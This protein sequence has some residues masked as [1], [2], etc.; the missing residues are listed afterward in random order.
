[1]A[2]IPLG[3]PKAAPKVPKE[4]QSPVN[5]NAP[6]IA[7]P[8]ITAQTLEQQARA[9]GE[10]P[11]FIPVQP[12]EDDFVPPAFVRVGTSENAQAYANITSDA[13]PDGKRI[14][15]KAQYALKDKEVFDGRVA[16][17]TASNKERV[18]GLSAGPG[19][20]SM[21]SIQPK[22][23]IH[24]LTG[25]LTSFG[26]TD[27]EIVSG[28]A[29]AQLRA[30][31]YAKRYAQQGVGTLIDRDES[32]L[33]APDALFDAMKNSGMFRNKEEEDF[34]KAGYGNKYSAQY[35]TSP[36]Q[37]IQRAYKDKFK[38][39]MHPSQLKINID[40]Y[41][42]RLNPKNPQHKVL[43]REFLKWEDEHPDPDNM[44]SR[45]GKNFSATVGHLADAVGNA[46][47][48]S[49]S[50]VGY[51]E[52]KWS[53]DFKDDAAKQ[54][55]E[56]KLLILASAKNDGEVLEGFSAESAMSMVEK[57]FTKEGIVD[58]DLLDEDTKRQ[59]PG[60][61]LDIA[62][63]V[64]EL[65][66][67]GAFDK[68]ING[69]T[70]IL[71]FMS[72]AVTGGIGL[73]MIGV[74]SDPRSTTMRIN[75]SV[76][77]ISRY[78]LDDDTDKVS[79]SLSEFYEEQQMEGMNT[80][81]GYA[82]WHHHLAKE[83]IFGAGVIDSRW[84]EGGSAFL[85]PFEGYA[86]FAGV[87]RTGK[88]LLGVGRANAGKNF[89]QRVGLQE[90]LDATLASV[91]VLARQ[92]VRLD[93]FPPDVR[94]MLE[95][96][97]R[98]AVSANEK[99]DIYE[100][101]RRAYEGKGKMLDP[102]NPSR[103]VSASEELLNSLSNSI[104][105]KAKTVQTMRDKILEAANAGKKVVYSKTAMD[106]IAKA[107]DEL[108]NIFPE[109]DWSKVPDSVVYDRLRRGTMP[110]GANGKP[111]LTANEL[112]ALTR[113]VGRGW[114][115]I[116][117]KDI[118][119]YR[120]GAQ[121]P[122][123]FNFVYDNPIFNNAVKL[124]KGIGTGSQW[125]DDL[126]KTYGS[127]RS[128]ITAAYKVSG[129]QGVSASTL[130]SSN[131]G[132]F[133]WAIAN[134]LIPLGRSIGAVGRGL[135]ILSEFGVKSSMAGADFDSA[136]LGIRAD[137]HA[138]M[139]QLLIRRASISRGK[140]PEIEKQLK[141]LGETT[142]RNE[143]EFVTTSVNAEKD[144]AAIDK[145]LDYLE[146]KADD[147][148][149]MHAIGA[150]GIISGA[151]KMFKDGM[152]AIGSNELLLGLTDNFAGIGG[153]TAYAGFGTGVNAIKSG[154][155][156]H[157]SRSTNLRERT[158]YDMG[159]IRTF[160]DGLGHDPS[161]DVQRMKIVKVMMKARDDAD[162][163]A[164]KSGDNAGETYFAKQ[165]FTLAQV[166]RSNANLVLTNAGTRNGLVSVMESVQHQ[167]P[168]FADAVK[169][170]YLDTA[171]KMGLTSKE[172]EAYAEKMKNGLMEAAAGR[173]RLGTIDKQVEL[174][175]TEHQVISDNTL[176]ELNTLE[177]ASKIIAEEAGLNV[178]DLFPTGFKI[179]LERKKA[180]KDKT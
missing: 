105:D 130:Q 146:A 147:I 128:G 73:A 138:E 164:L 113:E 98:D 83:G 127:P 60:L 32:L 90:S 179:E 69:L 79:K 70:S 84:H 27:V 54:S 18:M 116:D 126:E 131:P 142:V 42:F 22:P 135:E 78:M 150:N 101:V 85:T 106:T 158:N 46:V 41:G 104:T 95:G 102:K 21:G 171:L 177:A 87:A 92:G 143:P 26:K 6:D 173:T 72:A 97:Q 133:K 160:M 174:L 180:P 61:I 36:F 117:A 152:V 63:E 62:K 169:K 124:M 166:F 145:R 33:S 23:T 148:K 153:G 16:K 40:E 12:G 57:K 154:W 49:V 112:N 31:F 144:I 50:S 28:I 93:S 24:P 77:A 34:F 168:E 162:A 10:T 129:S 99:I 82:K 89:L 100:A 13:N 151:T 108:K 141:G 11:P 2:E 157:F 88:S 109:T 29:K 56:K 176:A 170:Q 139:R 165:M 45:F 5:G 59:I 71:T 30:D 17:W 76:N 25:F 44:A 38:G 14:A 175:E 20:V 37:M 81:A 119:G 114:R 52:I 159:S 66:E 48:T 39:T 75:N 132:I 178:E 53:G 15:S 149:R 86:V 67:K 51:P 167:D 161:G 120:S 156:A 55:L 94:A 125:L 91:D 3:A 111:I 80:G 65:D 110:I 103:L 163:I 9:R 122:V 121:L 115:R 107:R 123:Q 4:I 172:A 58:M 43:F 35:E 19:V 118:A 136:M 64:K 140:W 47:Y 134:S 155:T 7:P 8:M 68:D 137:A 96:I 74:N 1:M